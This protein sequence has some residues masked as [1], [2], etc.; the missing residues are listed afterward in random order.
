MINNVHQLFIDSTS[1][2]N[3]CE[4][5][6]QN[7]YNETEIKC[8]ITSFKFEDLTFL[9]DEITSIDYKRK[10]LGLSLLE[11][12]LKKAD[13]ALLVK[14]LIDVHFIPK[15][16]DI[17]ESDEFPILQADSAWVLRSLIFKSTN[18]QIT[19]HIDLVRILQSLIKL[20]NVDNCYTVKHF[21][22]IYL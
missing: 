14:R 13:G 3:K 4:A 15:L 10:Y 8:L 19:C 5:I 18:E 16:I 7:G 9:L 17:L 2:R 1:F 11:D 12:L 6:T 20:S 22:S 21:V